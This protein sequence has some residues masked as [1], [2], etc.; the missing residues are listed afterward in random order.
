MKEKML[1][2]AREKVRVTHKGKPIRLTADLS[3]ET[4]QARREWG[5]TFNILKEKNFQPRISYPA[6]LSFISEG[7]INFFANK[8]VLR[9]YITTRPALQELLKE[10]LH[11]DR[12]NQYQPFQKHT[13]RKVCLRLECSVTISAYCKLHLLGSSHPLT[14]A[15]RVAGTT[16]VYHH[17]WL[18]FVVFVEAG[19]CLVAQAGLKLSL[20]LLPRLEYSG[21]NSAHSN[22]YLP[23]SSDSQASASQ[24]GWWLMPVIPALWE[25]KAGRSLEMKFCSCCPG[26]SAMAK[27]QLIVTSTSRVQEILLPQPLDE[28]DKRRKTQ[29]VRICGVDLG[30]KGNMGKTESCFVAQA[31]VQWH[32]LGSLQTPP[33]GD[34]CA[35]ASQAAGII[36]THHYTQLIFEFLVEM[37]FYHVGQAS[38]ELLTTGD[39]P[40][41]TS[42][43]AGF[44][45]GR[46]CFTYHVECSWD[47][48]RSEAV[49]RYAL[50]SVAIAEAAAFDNEIIDCIVR[51]MLRLFVQVISL[52]GTRLSFQQLHAKVVMQGH[53]KGHASANPASAN[54]ASANPASANPASAKPASANPAS[55]NPASANPA[56]A[57]PA[58]ANPASANPASANPASANPASAKPASAPLK[59][60]W[61]PSPRYLPTLPFP[62]HWRQL[63]GLSVSATYLPLTFTLV[64]SLTPFHLPLTLRIIQHKQSQRKLCQGRPLGPTQFFF[65]LPQKKPAWHDCN[66]NTHKKYSIRRRK[67]RSGMVAHAC[68]PSTLGGQATWEAEAEESLE[69]QRKRLQRAKIVPLHSSLGEWNLALP[70]KLE[71]SGLISAHCNLH[72]LVLRDSSSSASQMESCSVARLECSGVTSAHYNLCLL[73]SSYSSASA[74]ERQDFIILARMVSILNL[75]IRP[76]WTPKAYIVSDKKLLSFLDLFFRIDKILLESSGMIIAHHSLEPLGSRWSQTPGFKRSSCL[77]LPRFWDYRLKCS[78]TISA[79]CN[80]CLPGSSDFPASAYEVAGITGMH[81]HSQLS[82]V[83]VVELGFHYVGPAGLE[84][85]TSGDLPSSASQSIGIT[86]GLPLLFGLAGEQ[87]HN[88]SSLQPQPPRLRC[89]FHLR[90][91]KMGSH[92]VTQ[93]GLKLLGSSD[94]PTLVSQSAEITIMS[95]CACPVFNFYDVQFTIISFLQFME[96]CSA[97]A[98]CNVCLPVSSNSSA[99]ASRV[100]GIT[101]TCYHDHTWLSFVYF[102]RDGVSPSVVCVVGKVVGGGGTVIPVAV[103]PSGAEQKSHFKSFY[104]KMESRSVARLECSGA[105]SAHCN[106]RLPDSSDFPASASEMEFYSCC[107]GLECNGAISAHCNLRLPGSR[108]FPASRVAGIISTR[109]HAWLIF[110]VLV[111]TGFHHVGQAGLELLTSGDPPTSAS[112]S[113]GITDVSHR[114]RPVFNLIYLLN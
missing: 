75:V 4:L 14:S 8:Q 52:T 1:R 80:L 68:N 18:I 5:P 66:E 85:L 32:D 39:S 35:S 83:L 3:A 90:L 77:G 114:A 54:P 15:S 53:G 42:Q 45:G 105:T 98:H 9:D 109:H 110:V 46:T 61:C 13:K 17:T 103:N 69:P 106:L 27:S 44:T 70:P 55:A 91:P 29:L 33:P 40:T 41:F 12:N 74:S 107:P 94:L 2:A 38:L 6:K 89:Y 31:G 36:G 30:R 79:H 20:P 86:G 72:L 97:S 34:F 37:G 100:A 84:L 21:V 57:N 63:F 48:D 73:G 10:A 7:K 23:V 65:K 50:I 60:L 19:F 99:S 25:A 81:H 104:F 101:G 93:I 59:S 16:G 87:Q 113:T 78:G 67:I 64:P 56:S 22:L 112:Q 26:W 43:S 51:K 92:Y 76:P 95:L 24:D 11:I 82:F 49:N 28:M 71:C 108:D 58:S 111:E 102:S 88:H 96:S 47:L 62:E